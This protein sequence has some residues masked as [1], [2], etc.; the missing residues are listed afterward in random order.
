M[1]ARILTSILQERLRK[2][3]REKKL[4]PIMWVQN[5]N[6]IDIQIKSTLMLGL[7]VVQSEW[8]ELETKALAII[9]TFVSDGITNE[10]L[11]LGEV[12]CFG[13]M[14]RASKETTTGRAV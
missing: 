4:V 13:H 11:E 10:E 9:E 2:S 12:K 5:G 8:A 1:R 14:R 7:D 6:T 3:L